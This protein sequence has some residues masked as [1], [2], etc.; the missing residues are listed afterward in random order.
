[1]IKLYS[2]EDTFVETDVIYVALNE[3]DDKGIIVLTGTAGAGK[4]RNSLEIL[5]R[6][7]T[8]H[9]GYCGI[10][11]NNISEWNDVINNGDRLIVVVDDIFG[12]TNCIFNAEEEKVFDNIY[13]MVSHGCVKVICT[14]RNTI[15]SDNQVSEIIDRNRIFKQSRFIDLSSTEFEMKGNQKRDCLLKYCKFNNILIS[16]SN[17]I[18]DDKHV[19]DP[20]VPTL[21]SVEE[22]YKI[23]YTDINP[24]IGYP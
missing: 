24:L 4:S 18:H 14:M 1:M 12:R 16:V 15:Q 5:Q 20:L 7:T 8:A 19:L 17:Q 22:T 9:D 13:S 21:L 3:L 2:S 6:F 23:A 11:L 10:K